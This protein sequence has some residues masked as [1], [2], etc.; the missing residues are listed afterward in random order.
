M[1]LK[2]Y[3]ASQDNTI[4]NAYKSNLVETGVSGNMGASDIL[5]VFS[6][7][8]QATTSSIEKTR[9]LIQFPI[10]DI[11]QDRSNSQIPA[12]GSVSFYLRLFNAK[13]SDFQSKD[14]KLVVAPVSQSWSEGIGL[15]MEEYNDEYAS[16]WLS[17]STGVTWTTQGGDYLASPRYEQTFTTGIEDMEIDISDL[18]EQWIAGTKSNYGVGIFLTSSQESSTTT[19]YY[20]KKFFARGTEFFFKKPIIE[21]RFN[22]TTRDNRGNFYYSSSLA[23]AAE[24]M[25]T[26]YLY[27]Y[28]NGKLRN[29]PAVGT[30]NI[31]VSLFSG[32]TVP[33]GSALTLVADG[34]RVT[35]GSPTVVTGGWVSTGV[36]TASF[37]I[38]AAS[39]PLD[40]L[41][42][43]WHN[44]NLTTQY[45]TSSISP[46]ILRAT[47]SQVVD[48]Y[49]TKITNLKQSYFTDETP[50]LRFYARPR[51]WN[52]NIYTVA[53][54][55]PQTSIIPSASYSVYRIAD[56]LRVIPH[57]TGS[58]LH[59][60]LSYDVSGNYFKFDMGMLEP[61][62]AYAFEIAIYNDA[63]SH[64]DVQPET[65]K[66]RVEKRQTE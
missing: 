30:G 3:T 6:L 22:D 20:T 45:A 12:S 38:T 9:I 42:D 21:A 11:I 28:Y 34:L 51:D 31:Y 7:A 59:T 64:W 35:A 29:I 47:N 40:T 44:G 2:R 43:V 5:E 52:F 39:T 1:T 8:K 17:A 24:N 36:Y 48:R 4:T 14:F 46:Q 55:T 10:T 49:N 32:S 58:T 63:T 53:Q 60:L 27:N 33:T 65:F 15:D 62:Y 37:A 41:F 61:D 23:T 25:N 19:S 18:V 13:H 66:F 54:E 16:N 56:D 50:F 26:V 57:G